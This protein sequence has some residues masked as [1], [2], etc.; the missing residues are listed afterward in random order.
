MLHKF[1]VWTVQKIYS[2][3]SLAYRLTHVTWVGCQAFELDGI[4]FVNDSISNTDAQRFAVLVPA[5]NHDGFIQVDCINFSWCSEERAFQRIVSARYLSPRIHRLDV[6]NRD[7]LQFGSEHH[8][9]E[10]CS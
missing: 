3:S 9:C 1:R 6:V 5:P 4:I 10:L 7:R 8:L 2:A